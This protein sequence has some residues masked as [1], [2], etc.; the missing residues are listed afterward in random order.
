MH[1]EEEEGRSEDACATTL[2]LYDAGTSFELA[3]S[4]PGKS[5]ELDFVVSALVQFIEFLGYVGVRVQTGGNLE[6]QQLLEW[7][8]RRRPRTTFLFQCVS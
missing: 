4:M 1:V 6:Y 2:G 8:Q 7:E 5:P 3:I